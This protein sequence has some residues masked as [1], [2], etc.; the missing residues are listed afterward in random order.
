MQHLKDKYS[1]VTESDYVSVA[2]P[3]WP[4]FNTFCEH[5][6]IDSDVY[7]E[8]DQMLTSPQKF[9]HPTFCVNPFYAREL[10]SN[11]PCCLLPHKHNINDIKQKMLQGER[12]PDC[13]ICYRL[14]DSGQDSDRLIKNRSIDH[15]AN[16]NVETLYLDAVAGKHQEIMYKID[17]SNACNSTCIT[18]GSGPSTSWGKLEQQNNI[19]PTTP[20]NV[21]I[22]EIDIDY[23]HAKMITFR[24]GE[25]LLSQTNFAVL[26]KLLD[27]GNT[28]C[29]ISFTTNTSVRP[30]KRQANILKSFNNI[31]MCF[32]I[33]GIGSVFEYMRYPLKWQDCVDN[34]EWSRQQGFGISVSYTISNLN[35]QYYAETRD[36]FQRNHLPYLI[37]PVCEPTWFRPGALPE[38]IK[39]QIQEQHAFPEL[40]RFLSSHTTQDDVDYQRAIHEVIKQDK[41]KGI[42]YLD[43]IGGSFLL[44]GRADPPHT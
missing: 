33:D 13:E 2:G 39:K 6:D 4:N 18:C 36:W 15:W 21:E 30:T 40:E 17:T 8:I 7:K 35:I 1:F 24:G 14:E 28:D 34:I 5:K 27:A 26:E 31:D 3:D 41:W 44:P 12:H 19:I 11:T 16:I 20:W 10:P 43:Y 42:S 38:S 37:N 23:A 22:D 9:D 25:P 29:F 32:S